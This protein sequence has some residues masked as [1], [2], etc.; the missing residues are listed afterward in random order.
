[1]W[2]LILIILIDGSYVANNTLGGGGRG[3][4]VVGAVVFSATSTPVR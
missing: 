1:M 2:T 4:E 3:S